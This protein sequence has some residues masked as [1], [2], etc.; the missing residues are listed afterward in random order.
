MGK[1]VRGRNG[2]G[3]FVIGRRLKQHKS[4]SARLFFNLWLKIKD[5]HYQEF[6]VTNGSS[7]KQEWEQKNWVSTDT[8]DKKLRMS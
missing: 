5:Y 1:S 4:C 3:L 7:G 2:L 8:G 6:Y